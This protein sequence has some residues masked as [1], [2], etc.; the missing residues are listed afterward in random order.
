MPIAI[1]DTS[2]KVD[3]FFAEHLLSMVADHK[4]RRGRRLFSIPDSLGKRSLRKLASLDYRT[5]FGREEFF[6]GYDLYY[7]KR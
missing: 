6:T 1:L 2:S 3:E 4:L 7:Y 5:R